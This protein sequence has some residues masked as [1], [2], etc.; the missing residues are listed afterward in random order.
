MYPELNFDEIQKDYLAQ[1]LIFLARVELKNKPLL[2]NIELTYLFEVGE[3]KSQFHQFFFKE[4]IKSYISKYQKDS[5][6][7]FS[8]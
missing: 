4:K 7:Y 5:Q 8:K 6:L 3:F 2:E 1:T